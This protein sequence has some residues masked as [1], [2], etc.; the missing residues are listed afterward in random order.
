MQLPRQSQS[1]RSARALWTA[2]AVAACTASQREPMSVHTQALMQCNLGDNS[3][4]CENRQT[5]T[6]DWLI[7][8]KGDDHAVEG[9]ASQTSVNQ[10]G[11]VGLHLSSTVT[12]TVEV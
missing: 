1:P 4:V 5:G 11:V 2:L 7:N 3:I 9:Y 6:S 10:N 8:V 12:S